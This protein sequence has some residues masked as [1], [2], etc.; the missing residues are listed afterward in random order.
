[1]LLHGSTRQRSDVIARME[2]IK[3]RPFAQ[4]FI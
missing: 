2:G 4:Y 3:G 1:M